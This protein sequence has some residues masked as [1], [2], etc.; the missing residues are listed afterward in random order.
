MEPFRYHVYVCEQ[1]KPEGIP[2][3][4]GNG[5]L[6]V[7]EGLRRELTEQGLAG[8]V[9]VTPCG[10]LGLCD[11]G[12]NM[13]VYPEGIWYSGVRPDDIPE[14]V[15]E[16]FGGGR[17]VQRLRSGDPAAVRGQIEGN[18]GKMM[19]ALRAREKAGVLPDEFQ[20]TLRGFQESRAL[21]TAI[22]VDLFTAVGEGAR[23]DAVARKLG[24]DARATEALLN[25]LTAMELLEKRDETF[26]N[27][28]LA[29]R[30]LVAG[31]RDDSRAAL[32]HTANLWS[33]WS[34]LTDCV[35]R[36]TAVAY[37]EMGE[38]GADWTEPF[39][40]AMHK[41]AALRAPLVAR[42]IGLEGV[43]RVL[44]V[45]GGSGAYAIAFAQA[46]PAL[47]AD[48]LDLPTVVPLANRY[49]QE[50]GVAGRVRTRTGDLHEDGYGEGYDLVLF[51]AICHM[52]S[53][54]EN[55]AMLARAFAALAPAGRVVIHDFILN[56]D[57]AGPKTGALF[58]LNMLV[59]TRAG[60]SY[61]GGEYEAW[62][63]ESGFEDIRRV[64]L[65][66]PT[67]LLIGRKP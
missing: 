21:L 31:G 2:C 36:G 8:E 65:P 29:G 39:I 1:R 11:W 58:A 34:T 62:L 38:R 12:P 19:D 49:I 48:I 3:C 14:I 41:N 57:K 20:Q 15:R 51:S 64:G 66:G 28:P 33:R 35:R 42:S 26:T 10:S 22:E 63:R 4:A 9:Q 17:V 6:K 16:H 24:T 32:M 30:F 7:I 60:S 13:V 37:R 45:G 44:D 25:A 67:A 18:R 50:A 52:N 23:A 55:R 46:Q 47:E 40:A 27:G 53:P 43:R 61:S 56:P 54:E 5:S 59:G